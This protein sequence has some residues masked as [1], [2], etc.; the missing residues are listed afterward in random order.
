MTA[1]V[2]EEKLFLNPL[3]FPNGGLQIKL[4]NMNQK[5]HKNLFVCLYRQE[6]TKKVTWLSKQ[7]VF[8]PNL[9]RER[10]WEEKVPTGRTNGFL[11]ERQWVFM[12]EKTVCDNV[13]VSAVVFFKAMKLPGKGIHGRFNPRSFW[14]QSDKGGLKQSLFLHLLI[15]KYLQLKR[16]FMPL[17]YNLDPLTCIERY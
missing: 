1:C 15:L 6:P 3:K 10:G 13:Y 8:I 16:I 7:K 17:W 14:F 9:R 11:Q 12:G 2:G 4:Q 5:R